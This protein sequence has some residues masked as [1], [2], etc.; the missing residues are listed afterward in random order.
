MSHSIFKFNFGEMYKLYL[1][2]ITKKARTEEELIEVSCWLTGYS[3]EEFLNQ[4]N[5][6]VDMETFIGNAPQLNP[7]RHLITGSICG[8]KIQEMEQSTMKEIRYYDKVVD[9]LAKGKALEKIMRK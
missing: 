6:D 3:K 4:L 5:S 8:V 7:N 1:A 9:E 2:K